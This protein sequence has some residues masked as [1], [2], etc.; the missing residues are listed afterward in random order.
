MSGSIK[1]CIQRKLL[2]T[3]ER[4]MFLSLQQSAQISIRFL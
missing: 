4:E 2:L 1:A 3:A